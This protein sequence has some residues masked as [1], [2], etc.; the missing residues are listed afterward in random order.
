MNAVVSSRGVPL[1]RKPEHELVAQA[2]IADAAA[3]QCGHCGALLLAWWRWCP[4]CG[5]GI[6]WSASANAG[7]PTTV[8]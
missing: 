1:P 3:G 5:K 2:A 4:I 7:D 8:R 6:E